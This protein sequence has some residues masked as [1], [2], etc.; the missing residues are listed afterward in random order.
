MFN[1]NVLIS[2]KK[3]NLKKLINKNRI[4]DWKFKTLVNAKEIEWFPFDNNNSI[5]GWGYT[6]NFKKF[7]KK[8]NIKKFN[9]YL[10]DHTG[11]NVN[12]IK[13]GEDY[14]SISTFNIS[15]P[16]IGFMPQDTS[17]FTVH[18]Q[19]VGVDNTLSW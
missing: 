12:S 1:N 19:S 11:C 10:G 13:K 7:L 18:S 5:K 8:E 9:H 4:S 2:K 6:E 3:K 17:S 14:Y 15:T 16:S